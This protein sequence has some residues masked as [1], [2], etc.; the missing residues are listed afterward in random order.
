M[1]NTGSPSGDRGV[2]QLATR[3][4]KAGLTGM[5][6]RLVV[7]KKPG[8]SGGGKGPQLKTDARSDDEREIGDE[9]GNSQVV[10]RSCR[11]RHMQWLRRLRESSPRAG[12]GKSAHPVR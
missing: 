10:F 7:L 12:C 2:D 3:E 4:R 8:N 11:R 6:E 9:P 1:R 5:A